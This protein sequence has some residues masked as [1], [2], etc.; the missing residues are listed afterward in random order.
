MEWAM[1][2]DISSGVA[3]RL[4][5]DSQLVAMLADYRGQPALFVDP[6]PDDWTIDLGVGKPTCIVAEPHVNES[7]DTFSSRFRSA[8][9]NVRL[10]APRSAASGLTEA[11]ETVRARLHNWGPGS[12]PGGSLV[13]ATAAGPQSAPTDDPSLDGRI[14]T[15]TLLIRET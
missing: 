11:A 10:Y 13:N 14:L 7:A 12:L 8:S 4:L 15:A 2:L 5:A 6:V 9:V 1:A 3:A